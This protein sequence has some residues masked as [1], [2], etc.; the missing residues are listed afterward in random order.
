VPGASFALIKDETTVPCGDSSFEV[1]YSSEVIEHLFDVN[2][3]IREIHRVLVPGGLFLVT[4]PYHGWLK[5]LLIITLGFDRH[6]DV[7]WGHI[8]FFSKQSLS[9][10]LGAGGFEVDMIGGIGRFWPLWKSMFVVA[11]KR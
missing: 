3:F 9:R 8:R 5:N 2:G 7:N 10:C 6:F 4:T 1:C 11:R